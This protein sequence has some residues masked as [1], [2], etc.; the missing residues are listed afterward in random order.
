MPL[1]TR[2]TAARVNHRYHKMPTSIEIRKSHLPNKKYNAVI[3]GRRT[4]PFGQK[5]A[6]DF[7]VHKDPARKDRYIRR[8]QANENWNDP[9]TAGFYS[10]WLTWEKPTMRE[11]VANANR[12]FKNVHIKL[13]V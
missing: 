8:R 10:R 7:T 1:L 11:A 6:A 13:N 12:K 5:G 9:T 4:I 2:R 3:D